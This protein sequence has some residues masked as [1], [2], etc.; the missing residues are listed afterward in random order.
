MFELIKSILKWVIIVVLFVLLIVLLARLASK[1]E[2]SSATPLES[3]V[4]SVETTL[5]S[6]EF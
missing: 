6:D 4:Q 1:K 5:D 2:A 3:G